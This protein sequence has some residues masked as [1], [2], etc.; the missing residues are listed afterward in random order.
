MSEKSKEKHNSS[1]DSRHEIIEFSEG[2]ARAKESMNTPR[3]KPPIAEGS[4]GD[5]TKKSDKSEGK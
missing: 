5:D 3:P 4:S 2:Q 1:Q